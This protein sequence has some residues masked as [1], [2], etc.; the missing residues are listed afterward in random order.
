MSEME[1]RRRHRFA[2]FMAEYYAARHAD[3]L[4]LEAATAM[5][6]AEVAEY[7]ARHGAPMN[8]KRWLIAS[9][10]LPR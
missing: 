8:F 9:R 5:Y 7:V 6:A 4:E 3:L 2:C 10:G 1:R